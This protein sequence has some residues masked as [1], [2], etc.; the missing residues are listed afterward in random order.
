VTLQE[1]IEALELE[2]EV[3]AKA[4]V[5]VSTLPNTGIVGAAIN[6]EVVELECTESSAVKRGC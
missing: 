1:A 3:E 6:Y 5:V 4:I 2:S